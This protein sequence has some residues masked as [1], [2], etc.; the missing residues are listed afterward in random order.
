MGLL[1]APTMEVSG[2]ERKAMEAEQVLTTS[3]LTKDYGH[4][5]ALD[6]AD[7]KISRGAIYGF[8]GKNGAGKTTLMRVVSGLQHP[9]S[10]TYALFG[11]ENQNRQICR[12]RRRAGVMVESPAIAGD[13]TAEQ[14]LVEQY[15]VLGRTP[16]NSVREL[17]DRVGLPGT[18]NKKAKKFSLGM[19][20]RLGIAVALCGDPDFLM[21][22]EPANGL[23]P[24]GIIEVREL[25][26][27]LNRE[28]GVT[29]LVSSH[30]LEELA[31]VATEFGFIDHGR[32]IRQ[33]SA[34][35]L[36]KACRNCTLMTVSDTAALARTLDAMHIEYRI[37]SDSEAEVY[38]DHE[39]TR[40][41]EALA[42]AGC[43][44]SSM[45]E[46]GQSLEAYYL[47]LIGGGRGA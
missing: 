21:L 19:R 36:H 27:R 39:V 11:V 34:E 32:I 1:L 9:T 22:D 18:G 23:D 13:L 26:L 35:D 33:I 38:G 5:R 31:Q 12:E 28:H 10:G 15:K 8:I 44:V 6:G 14:N 47:D 43:T 24:E 20:Q 3:A 17:L 4:T 7:M 42:Q 30:I 2:K 46:Q 25:M 37:V 45:K 40:L 29:I 41:V 16:D